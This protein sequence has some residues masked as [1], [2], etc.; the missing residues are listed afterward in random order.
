MNSYIGYALAMNWLAL[1]MEE[2]VE[3]AGEVVVE[4]AGEEGRGQS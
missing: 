2:K 1:E 4:V 3:G